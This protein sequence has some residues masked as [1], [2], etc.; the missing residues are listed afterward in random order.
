[1]CCVLSGTA[2]DANHAMVPKQ[3]HKYYASLCRFDKSDSLGQRMLR[4]EGGLL[5]NLQDEPRD[6][7]LGVCGHAIKASLAPYTRADLRAHRQVLGPIFH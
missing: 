3:I 4:E 1:M 2:G 5:R 7:L 6:E